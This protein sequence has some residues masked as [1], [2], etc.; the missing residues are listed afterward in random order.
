MKEE[1]KQDVGAS[2]FDYP[3]GRN[4]EPHMPIFYGNQLVPH[5][6]NSA[7]KV[8]PKAKVMSAVLEGK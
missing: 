7:A 1:I 2:A 3:N 6:T 8:T 4:P 5:P